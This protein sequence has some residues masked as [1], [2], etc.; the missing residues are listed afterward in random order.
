MTKPIGPLTGI[1]GFDNSEPEATAEERLGGTADPRH[2]NIGELADPYPWQ[3][4]PGESHGPYGLE[5]GLLGMDI[6]VLPAGVL[7]ND[8]TSDQQPIT[9][10]APWPKGVP[11]STDPA[12]TGPWRDQL[13]GIHSENYGGSREMLYEPTAYA[14]Q[15]EWVELLET[16][17]GLLFPQMEQIPGQV[18]TSGVGG[19]GGRDRAT[20]YARQNQHGFD[21]AHMHRRYA[22]GSIPGNFMWM[23]PGSRPLVKT[24]PGTAKLPVGHGSPFQGQ[25]PGES[26]DAQ[27]S[28]LLN[29]PVTY[30][31][32]PDP[33]LAPSFPT[34]D[35]SPGIDLW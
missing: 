22:T 35:S 24:I 11:T 8:P 30:T 5:N 23:D 31:P 13:D 14:Q 21:S 12:D 19:W 1:V 15:D 7:E 28:A 16:D 20:S 10:A 6:C 27:G 3:R 2:E 34:A 18:K 29:L 17:P 9:R 33:S 32:P 25:D 4:F 26:F